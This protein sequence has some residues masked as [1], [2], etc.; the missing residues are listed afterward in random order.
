[1]GSVTDFN[2]GLQSQDPKS[3]LR[4]A[5]NEFLPHK[6]KAFGI[7]VSRDEVPDVNYTVPQQKRSAVPLGTYGALRNKAQD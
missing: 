5:S 3:H 4:M 6:K 7:F 2:C 1:M